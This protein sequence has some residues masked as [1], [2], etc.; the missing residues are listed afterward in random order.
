M[1]RPPCGCRTNRHCVIGVVSGQEELELFGVSGAARLADGEHR[2]LR[3]RGVSR[4][5]SSAPD[6]EHLW[7]RGQ[8]GEGP[9]DFRDFAEL[10]VPCA[11]DQSIMIYDIYNRRIT[12]FD[13]DGDVASHVPLHFSGEFAL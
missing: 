9:G 7:S 1:L 10:L 6:G 13:G 11:S 8:E 12:A 5:R 3:E 2:G 4:C